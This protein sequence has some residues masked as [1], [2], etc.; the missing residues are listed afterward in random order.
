MPLTL[1]LTLSTTLIPTLTLAL[2]PTPHPDP[3]PHQLTVSGVFMPTPY[4]G[5]KAMRAGLI[6]D[7]YLDV[8]AVE[9]HKKV[10]RTTP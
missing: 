7:T 1:T 3:N 4:T 6:T 8:H 2:T 5:F 9:K 10:D